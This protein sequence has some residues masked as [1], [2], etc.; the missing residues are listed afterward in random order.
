M[1]L[2]FANS[3][4]IPAVTLRAALDQQLKMDSSPMLMILAALRARRVDRQPAFL[5]VDALEDQ[6]L[7]MRRPAQLLCVTIPPHLLAAVRVSAWAQVTQALLLLPTAVMVATLPPPLLHRE[8]APRRAM[9]AIRA[10]AMAVTAM[11]MVRTTVELNL[12][13]VLP[14]QHRSPRAVVA[15]PVPRAQLL[16]PLAR[17]LNLR[18]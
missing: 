11:S 2:R 4:V 17:A 12:L 1:L 6:L 5:R 9:R 15:V 10:Q 8:R 16:A 7:L 14:L 3:A 18:A 13:L